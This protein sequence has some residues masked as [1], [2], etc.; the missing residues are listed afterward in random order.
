M[1]R[2]PDAKSASHNR[3][4]PMLE[5]S[6]AL[7]SHLPR[8]EDDITKL[9]YHLDHMIVYFAGSNNPPDLA[10]RPIRYLFL[11]EVDKLPA[12]SGKEVDPI[13]LATER[14]R[15]FWNR[16]IVKVS[17]PTTRQ[18]YIFREYKKSDRR[19]YYVPCP[20]C[21][22]YQILVFNQIKWSEEERDA[23]KIRTKQLA[24]HECQHCGEKIM[25]QAK[26]KM[27]AQGIW[28]PEG[29]EITSEGQ[30]KGDIVESGHRVSGYRFYTH[31]GLP[32]V[33]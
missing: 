22:K 13:K 12:F 32:G 8:L 25:E 30:L 14:T 23:E 24:W 31:L 7:K 4:Q 15:T 19:R 11:D 27:I 28:V 17:T 5:S 29:V 9:E 18:G 1:P 16:K 3:I 6:P 21:G 2:V 10:Q 20:H 26:A 33:M